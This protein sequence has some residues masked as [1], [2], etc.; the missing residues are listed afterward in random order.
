MRELPLHLDPEGGPGYLQLAEQ[1]RQAVKEGRVQAGELLPS[2]RRLAAQVG[3]HRHT[4]LRAL[5][6]LVSEGWLT[7]EP[8]RGF[9]VTEQHFQDLKVSPAS[10][11]Q[12]PS[13]PEPLGQE[14]GRYHFHSGLPDLRHFPKD[15][16]FR[17]FRAVMREADPTRLLSYSFPGGSERFRA[18]LQEYLRRI[19]GLM[20]GQIVVTHGSQEAIFLLAQLLLRGERRKVVVEALGY[21]QA[22]EAMRLCGAELVGLPVDQDGLCVDALE[23][24]VADGPPALIYLTPL[25]HYPTTVTLSRER[26]AQLLKIITR[27]QIPVL[28]DDYDH[29]FHYSGRPLTPLASED[30]SGLV[31]YVSTFSKL[32]YPSA[33]LGYAVVPEPLFKPLNRLKNWSS[34]Q[35][36]LLLQEAMVRWMEGGGLERHLRRMRLLY[37]GRM[38]VMMEGLDQMGL[39]YRRPNGGMSLWVDT[40]KDSRRVAD[41]AKGMGLALRAGAAYHLETPSMPETHLRLGFAGTDTEEIRTGLKLLDR[42]IAL[43]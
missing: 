10:W 32:V 6:E 14:S 4:V 3:R 36:D 25:H 41:H 7:S 11:P 29:E 35:N 21:R 24:L 16:F 13:F 30:E 34:R 37:R 15:E 38:E 28:E 39:A 31:L 18:C 23:E 26:R 2:T 9:R 12:L 42:A 27:H 40:G 5:E 17:C 1:I 20:K 33:R 43:S 19:R 22:W 8:G